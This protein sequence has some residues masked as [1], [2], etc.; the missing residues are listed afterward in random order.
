MAETIKLDMSKLL[1]VMPTI[2]AITDPE[3]LRKAHEKAQREIA[4]IRAEE[5]RE[6]REAVQAASGGFS[7]LGDQA[8]K[9]PAYA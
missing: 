6:Q 4:R 3:I 8:A 5:A 2:A 7:P 9:R 1:P